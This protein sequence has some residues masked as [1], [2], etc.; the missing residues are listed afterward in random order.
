MRLSALS[1]VTRPLPRLG[2]GKRL[3]AARR[4]RRQLHLHRPRFTGRPATKNSRRSPRAVTRPAS[5]V[6]TTKAAVEKTAPDK[7]LPR[8]PP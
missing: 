6:I 5:L 8:R 7:V 1:R 3:V 2:A 4:N